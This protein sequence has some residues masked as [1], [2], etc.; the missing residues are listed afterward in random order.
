M[1]SPIVTSGFSLKKFGQNRPPLYYVCVLER[2]RERVGEDD[3]IVGGQKGTIL[4][5]IHIVEGVKCLSSKI[6]GVT[7]KWSLIK[8]V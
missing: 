3:R 7:Q 5:Y 1:G 8:G 6:K 4:S 2:E